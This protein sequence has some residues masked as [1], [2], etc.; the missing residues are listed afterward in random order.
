[1]CYQSQ[2][3]SKTVEYVTNIRLKQKINVADIRK[4]T[5]CSVGCVKHININ[6]LLSPIE[7]VTFQVLRA[8]QS[9]SASCNWLLLA[10]LRHYHKCMYI[11]V[12]ILRMRKRLAAVLTVCYC[13]L[14]EARQSLEKN[15]V[16]PGKSP[17]APIHCTPISDCTLN[18]NS[19]S[20][21]KKYA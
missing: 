6:M 16:T 21:F 19:E 5:R 8:H 2:N 1:M 15:D 12:I 10:R 14:S 18:L 17:I 3:S 11:T 13:T 7:H 20:K 9:Y 4:T